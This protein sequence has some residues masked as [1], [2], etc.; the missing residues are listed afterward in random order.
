[1]ISRKGWRRMKFRE[2]L[3]RTVSLPGFATALLL[4]IGDA[5]AQTVDYGGLQDLFGEPVTTSATGKPQKASE[6]PLALEIITD[7]QIRRMGVASLPEVLGRIS[8]LSRWQGTR[9]WADVGIRG[10]NTAYNP[11]LLVLLNGRQVYIDVYG[12]TDWTL[13]P[14]QMEEIRQIEIVKSPTT[15]LYGFN[16]VS[17]V[18]NIVTYNPQYD[19]VAQAG[20][21]GG[22]DAYGRA[23]GFKTL[24]VSEKANVRI[25]ASKERFSEFDL[26]SKTNFVQNSIATTGNDTFHDADTEKFMADGLLQLN[27]TTQLRLESAYAESGGSDVQP[28]LYAVQN[29]KTLWSGKASL[30]SDTASWGLVEANFYVN[31]YS[32]S[33]GQG[34][35][36][37]MDN[38]IAVAQLQDLFKIGT[39]HTFRLQGEYRRNQMESDEVIAPGA[40]LSYQ[41]L[42]TGGM[43]NW[44]ITPGLEWTNALRVDH[45]MLERDGPLLVPTPLSS[46]DDFNQH[47][48][49]YSV[50]SGIAWKASERDTW[51]AS[52]GRGIQAPSLVQFGLTA[53]SGPGVA[54]IGDPTLEPIVVEQYEIGYDRRVTPIDGQFR[55]SLFYKQTSDIISFAAN[56][57]F[58]A[59]NFVFQSGVIGDSATAGLELTLQGKIQPA[60][61]WD[62]SYVYQKT[63]DDLMPVA[64]LFPSPVALRYEDVIPHHV[65]KGHVGYT[66]GQWETDLYA[67]AASSFDAVIGAGLG[68]YSLQHLDGYYTLGGRV[69]YT[70]ENAFTLALQG[71]DLVQARVAN[72]YGMENERRLFL[73][74]SKRF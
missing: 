16:A 54:F 43:W 74:L 72:N 18:I 64:T 38:Q 42:A 24:T 46:N 35:N 45:L 34:F 50:N 70:F 53:P 25:S 27:D 61:N 73:S 41:V 14:V 8:G 59:P 58:S 57:Y 17:G 67:E 4:S 56:N 22:T 11:T 7:D 20:V 28:F 31:N 69:G 44:A 49:D 12:Y 19:D 63:A 40:E 9:Y 66:V 5:A 39:D 36:L 52:Y 47:L 30:T 26:R 29:D 32:G 71:A 60:W 51:R 68:N 2:M 15:A 6:A 1:M 62:V 21:I 23:Y 13:I 37:D 3:Y 48:T 65:L 33:Y 55:S 10:R